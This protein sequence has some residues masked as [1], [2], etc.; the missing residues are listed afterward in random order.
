MNPRTWKTCYCGS[1]SV[2]WIGELD[3]QLFR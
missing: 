3:I 1:I 2:K